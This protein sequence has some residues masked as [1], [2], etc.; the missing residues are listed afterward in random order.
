MFE[1]AAPLL[2]SLAAKNNI[3]LGL[4]TGKSRRGVDRFIEQNGLHGIFVTL[5]TA[6]TPRRSRIRRCFCKPWRRPA[7]PPGPPR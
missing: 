4:A 1:G 3:L 2:F 6:E 5:Q 7:P